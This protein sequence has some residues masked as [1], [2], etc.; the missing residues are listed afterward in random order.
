[1]VLIINQEFMAKIFQ[2][3]PLCSD[4]IKTS[5]HRLMN[6]KHLNEKVQLER[7]MKY[8]K[9]MS[10]P[11]P[12]HPGKRDLNQSKCNIK[13]NHPNVK[14]QYPPEIPFRKFNNFIL[15]DKLKSIKV[16]I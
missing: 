10:I 3:F 11:S 2:I 5:H 1:M 7:A 4:Q 14:I 16:F 9:C 12:Q 8:Q 6:K 15:F 13:L